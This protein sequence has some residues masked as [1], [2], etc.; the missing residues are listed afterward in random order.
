MV[1]LSPKHGLNPSL[2]VCFLCL[3]DIGVALVGRILKGDDPEAP[4]RMFDR[5][6]CAECKSWM[7]K[8]II[9]IS[10][11]ETKTTDSKNPFRTGGWVVVSEDYVK[12]ILNPGPLLEQTLKGRYA[13]VPDELWDMLKLPRGTN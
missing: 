11:D 7:E 5:E 13:V 1:T 3:K 9:L 6:P 2:T 4:R 10:V 8:G 12:H